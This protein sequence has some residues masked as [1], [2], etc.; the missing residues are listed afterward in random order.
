MGRKSYRP[1]ATGFGA[2]YFAQHMLKRL[3]MDIEGLTFSVSGL[4]M[5]PGELLLK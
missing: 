2:V 1:E 4:E 3:G 5:L